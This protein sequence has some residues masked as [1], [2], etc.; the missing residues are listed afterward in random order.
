MLFVTW[1]VPVNFLVI[2][3]Y[4]GGERSGSSPRPG[5]H[6]EDVAMTMHNA[7]S[8]SLLTSSPDRYEYQAYREYNKLDLV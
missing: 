8:L 4:D 3:N 7:V 2:G 6:S 1:T 5:T